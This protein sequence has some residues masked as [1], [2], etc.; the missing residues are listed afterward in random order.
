MLSF[1]QTQSWFS[2]FLFSL[3]S[4]VYLEYVVSGFM[5]FN[6]LPVVDTYG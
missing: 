6:K 1:L 5:V 2:Q 3:C 4:V